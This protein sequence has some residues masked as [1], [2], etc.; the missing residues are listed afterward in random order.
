MKPKIPD[1]LF[2]EFVAAVSR[3][4]ADLESAQLVYKDVL[5]QLTLE[6][7]TTTLFLIRKLVQS[8]SAAMDLTDE[9]R[10]A[11]LA[12]LDYELAKY[13]S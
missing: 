9:L 10:D 4:N 8:F 13:I 12:V 2:P 7:K 1:E 5:D 3:L 6:E 11:I